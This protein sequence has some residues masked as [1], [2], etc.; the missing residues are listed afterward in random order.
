MNPGQNPGQN[1]PKDIPPSGFGLRSEVFTDK[2]LPSTDISLYS[3]R[4]YT[5]KPDTS[6]NR[7]NQYPLAIANGILSRRFGIL[8]KEEGSLILSGSASRSAYFN[9]IEQGGIEVIPTEGKWKEAVPILEQELR[10]AVQFGFT[11]EELKEE[12]ELQLAIAL[13]QSEAQAKEEQ[14]K[15]INWFQIF[16]KHVFIF[17]K[18]TMS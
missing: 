12:E 9:M 11:E 18:K 4:P 15:R 5:Q 10:K 6:T 16:Q 7:I 14:K 17:N 2:E 8:A 13:S 1:P 3:L